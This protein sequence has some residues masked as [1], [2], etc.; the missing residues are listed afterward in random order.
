[1]IQEKINAMVQE[2]QIL[3]DIKGSKIGQVNA[4]SVI[5]MGDLM[6]G[7]PNRITCSI[8]LGKAGIVTIEREAELS[9]PIHTKDKV[10]KGF[11]ERM[12][13]FADGGED[14]SARQNGQVHWVSDIASQ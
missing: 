13:S 9:G 14:E 10:L 3:I 1:M 6:F 8:N 4:L 7:K 11:S 12:K 2:K 5:D